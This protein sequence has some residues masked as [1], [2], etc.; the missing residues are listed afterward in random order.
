MCS[1][2]TIRAGWIAR[3]PLVALLA[4]IA[5]SETAGIDVDVDVTANALVHG[6]DDRMEP[7]ELDDEELRVLAERRAVAIMFPEALSAD[8][9]LDA[10][11]L[12]E[13]QGLC[14]GQ[15]FADQPSAAV[16]SGLLWAPDLVLT[17]AHC[18]RNV[19]CE[20]MRLVLGYAVQPGGELGALHP[21]LVFSCEEV[22][23]AEHSSASS[24]ERID[25]A[26]IRLD[27]A[28]AQLDANEAIAVR[29]P[30][31]RLEPG[32]PL[33][34]F[35]FPSGLPLKIDS[36][37]QV[38][39]ARDT[40]RDYFIATTDSFH[41]SSGAPVFDAALRLV[42]VHSRGAMDY[43]LVDPGCRNVVV[44]QEPSES[45]EEATYAFHAIDA[46]PLTHHATAATCTT[47]NVRAHR[48]ESGA[49]LAWFAAVALAWRAVLKRAP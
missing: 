15:R 11:N 22:V 17:A 7:Y 38:V 21:E 23:A 14:S 32:E 48:T 20:E 28:A 2:W 9:A 30:S 24:M 6:Q 41:G 25:F 12:A 1:A 27:R 19:P 4:S 37:A 29:D 18:V 36:G 35:G 10:P 40:T 34:S 16:C 31:D 5:C 46:L 39:D 26:W 44:V 45:R 13:V 49:A 33:I 3:C 47:A 43:E 8:L 42:G